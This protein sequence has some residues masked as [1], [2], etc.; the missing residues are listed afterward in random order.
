M[1]KSK[2]FTVAFVLLVLLNAALAGVLIYLLAGNGNPLKPVN[3]S[4]ADT[5]EAEPKESE[6]EPS[7]TEPVETEK[8]LPGGIRALM[9]RDPHTF[10]VVNEDI[11]FEGVLTIVKSGDNGEGIVFHAK[12]KFDSAT[13]EGNRI[14]YTGDFNITA[15]IY[16]EDNGI[17]YLMYKTDD[18]F[19]VTSNSEYVSF[20]QNG[21][22]LPSGVTGEY[23][24]DS[25]SYF[26][27]IFRDDRKHAVFSLYGYDG[28][29]TFVILSNVVAV[30]DDYGNASFEY[31]IDVS[32]YATG[33]LRFEDTG[34]RR[35]LTALFYEPLPLSGGDLSQVVLYH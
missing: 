24:S 9:E 8:P 7:E 4:V 16:I 23:R 14:Y 18:G 25:S 34:D 13:E 20:K 17:P 3:P 30:Y 31:Q 35:K 27:T 12:P 11:P 28:Q 32:Q 15:K 1:F 22:A 29:N 10:P 19:Y 2:K 33:L 21:S 26:I 5:S 6:E